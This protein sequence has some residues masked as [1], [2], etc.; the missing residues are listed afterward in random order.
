MRL[1]LTL[2]LLCIFLF[3]N[4]QKE[5]T[6]RLEEVLVENSPI[7]PFTTGYQLESIKL[8]NETT[9]LDQALAENPSIYFKSYG[10]G[11]LASIAF[12]GSSAYHTNVLWHGVP[13]NYP[14]LGQMD[15]SQ[16][17]IWM[18]ESV[19]LQPG[20]AGALYGSGSIGGTVLLDSSEPI[21]SAS[22]SSHLSVEAGS[23][24]YRF[25]GVKSSYH[26]G[27]L[28]ASTKAFFN[29]IDNDFGYEYLGERKIQQ[30]AASSNLGFQ[31]KLSYQRNNQALVID[32]MFNQN[33]RQIQ[34]SK[35]DQTQKTTL[36][37]DNLR[38]ALIH[39][40][41]HAHSSLNNTFSFQQNSTLYQDTSRTTSR[42][43]SLLNV[44]QMGFGDRI[45][46]R[47][48]SNINALFA[49]SENYH[50]RV[51][52]LQFSLFTSLEYESFD[53][54]KTSINLRQSFY[55]GNNP[56]TPSLGNKFR[57]LNQENF[58]IWST[59]QVSW[60]FRYPSLN[61]LYW[62]PG[63][64]RDLLPEKSF[65]WEAGIK[66]EYLNPYFRTN[67]SGN[68]YHTISKDWIYWVPNGS[69]FTPFNIRNVK[70]QGMELNW[71]VRTAIANIS[72]DYNL[73]FS[74]NQAI[75]QTGIYKGNQMIYVP[76]YNWKISGAYS[77][78]GWSLNF[79]GMQTDLRYTSLDNSERLMVDGFTIWNA[80][81]S[82]KI[83]L[84]HME[85]IAGAT[86]NNLMDVNYENLKNLAMPGRN[87]TINLSFKF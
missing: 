60:G 79:L 61:E 31:Q 33:N 11:Q 87:C 19:A 58:K 16:W 47:V 40:I 76:M 1:F 50:S 63:G 46:I 39:K 48:G 69:A 26:I 83:E 44:Y 24:G 45:S 12:R 81:I 22:T 71:N 78:S 41:E 57:L 73:S 8:K 4:G 49:E 80:T 21:E 68:I 34:P 37:T 15:F 14:T 43:L 7:Y 59:Q 25:V 17:P 86:V 72:Q 36:V 32:A 85:F 77:Y 66:A 27:K 10:N 84:S 56:F 29:S 9:N 54:W 13:A 51:D 53:W 75:N 30:N 35:I 74:V 52:D 38:L 6:L 20:N 62:Q 65:G 42:Q 67:L 3:A 82:K 28:S 2:S 18:L 64:N 70:L 5:D 55:K 23:F